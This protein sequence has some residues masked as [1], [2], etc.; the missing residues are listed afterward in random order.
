MEDGE[1]QK[2]RQLLPSAPSVLQ[3][4]SVENQN[5]SYESEG[6]WFPS[7]HALHR[8][9]NIWVVERKQ[10]MVVRS[11][12]CFLTCRGMSGAI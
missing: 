4:K 12:Y 10:V 9:L 5:Y 2:T 8:H 1:A 7:T 11:D 6:V 3:F